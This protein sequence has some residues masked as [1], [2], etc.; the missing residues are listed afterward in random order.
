MNIKDRLYQ[1][2]P[3]SITYFPMQ[4]KILHALLSF[5]FG[6]A[7]GFLAKYIEDIPHFVGQTGDSLNVLS[8][9]MSRI[10]IWV[11]IAT[12]ISA[13]SRTPEAGALHVFVFFAG[14][15]ITYYIYSMVIFHFFPTYYFLRWG[16]IALVAPIA[17]FIVWYSKGEGWIASFCAALPIGLLLASGYGFYGSFFIWQGFDLF[18]AILLYALLPIGKFQRLRLIPLIIIVF[19][20]INKANVLSFLFGGL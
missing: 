20:I 9:I 1:V 8:I 16:S 6:I 15:L 11:L 19:L 5:A 10:G 3:P 2:R 14:M 13:W 17:A 18:S 4:K 7:M 12:V